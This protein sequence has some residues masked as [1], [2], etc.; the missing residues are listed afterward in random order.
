MHQH[1]END[2]GLFR[3]CL[4]FLI[5][6][7]IIPLVF[8]LSCAPSL[9][10]FDRFFFFGCCLFVSHFFVQSPNFIC[11]EIVIHLNPMYHSRWI[12]IYICVLSLDFHFSGRR[13]LYE[14][15][16]FSVSNQNDNERWLKTR[17]QIRN[18]HMRWNREHPTKMLKHFIHTHSR[19]ADLILVLC[20]YVMLCVCV[21]ISSICFS[22]HCERICVYF[23]FHLFIFRIRC[24]CRA[25]VEMTK[26]CLMKWKDTSKQQ[27]WHSS[28]THTKSDE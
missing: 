20:Y 13:F 24:L 4:G 22:C 3:I 19:W 27:Q 26:D 28:H 5:G 2:F 16:G 17:K 18:P 15:N 1:I 14:F 9:A 23:L 10:H 8:F 25:L 21:L 11:T 7:K 6:Y 12:Y